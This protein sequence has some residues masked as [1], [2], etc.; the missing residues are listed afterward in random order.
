MYKL[1]QTS[2]PMPSSAAH[3]S[4]G[5]SAIRFYVIRTDK[6]IRTGFFSTPKAAIS[7]AC[8]KW[9]KDSSLIHSLYP[10]D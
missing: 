2:I 1:E 5:R 9:R 10:F 6:Y 4:F 8:K 3:P 7:A